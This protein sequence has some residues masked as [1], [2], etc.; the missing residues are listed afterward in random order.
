MGT[1]NYQELTGITVQARTRWICRLPCFGIS[2]SCISALALVSTI[3]SGNQEIILVIT[4]LIIACVRIE[5][6]SCCVQAPSSGSI[7]DREIHTRKK[8]WSF[9]KTTENVMLRMSGSEM[10]ECWFVFFSELPVNYKPEFLWKVNVIC[11][12]LCNTITGHDP[13]LPNLAFLTW[14]QSTWHWYRK[15]IV[16]N[17]GFYLKLT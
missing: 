6:Q 12:T 8:Y 13:W 9:K 7:E 16:L 15:R 3:T 1:W 2:K 14:T 11:I 4:S 10:V 5:A 17:V